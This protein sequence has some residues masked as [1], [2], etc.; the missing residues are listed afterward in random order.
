MD[1]KDKIEKEKLNLKD[2]EKSELF[3]VWK[4]LNK[5]MEDRG[6]KKH[7]KANFKY[8]EFIAQLNKDESMNGIFS[9][10]D[11]ANP[12]KFIKAYYEYIP[13]AKLNV[14]NVRHFFEVINESKE[15]SS[16]IILFSGTLTPQAKVKFQEINSQFP[17]EIFS[18][19]E[20]VIN[21]TENKLVPKHIL[22][23][24]EEKQELLKRYKIKDSQ[25]PK[26]LVTDPV[27]KYFGLKK[28]EVVKIIR[29]SKITGQYIT[30]RIAC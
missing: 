25:L 5:M 8:E 3:K 28:G 2:E 14:E 18:L 29:S 19:G 27:A 12:K 30:Y 10:P 4:T 11:P 7:E 6:Y 13:G 23:K 21:I 24:P 22:L 1:K 15:I 20:L 9:K 26:I 16:G 17:I